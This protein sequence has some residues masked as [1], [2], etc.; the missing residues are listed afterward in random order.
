MPINSAYDKRSFRFSKK[1]I[2]KVTK[3]GQLKAKKRGETKVTV[4]CGKEKVST[5]KMTVTPKIRKKVKKI[6]LYTAQRGTIFPEKQKKADLIL[7][8]VSNPATYKK[9]IY[10]SSNE[11]IVTVDKKGYITT[12]KS[13]KAKITAY[14]VDGSGV[15][16]SIKIT[17]VKPQA[18]T[19]ENVTA[20]A[21]KKVYNFSEDYGV[22]YTVANKS[23]E[24]LGYSHGGGVLYIRKDEHWEQISPEGG[25]D[26]DC[27]WY[28]ILPK[29]S[30]SDGFV[31]D[32]FDTS[33]MISG[34]YKYC[35]VYG[36]IEVSFTF[37]LIR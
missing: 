8:Y 33:E 29:S 19:A 5:V 32:Y 35:Y 10:K 20:K 2:V 23:T 17:V 12:K 21:D 14:A 11:K 34:M 26:F 36:G 31:F 13:G 3:S 28:Y 25:I 4:Y 6:G 27:G 22:W 15:K 9:L 18:A 1:G 7:G 37:E 24:R 16:E 30:L